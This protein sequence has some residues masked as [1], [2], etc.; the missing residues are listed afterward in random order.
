MNIS[1]LCSIVLESY[2]KIV[3]SLFMLIIVLFKKSNK[4]L[5]LIY[6]PKIYKMG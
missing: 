5:N 4:L 2:L 3:L 6:T 1:N